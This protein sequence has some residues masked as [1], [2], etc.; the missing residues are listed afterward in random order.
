VQQYPD[1]DAQLKE[2]LKLLC[3]IKDV[4]R[5]I[6]ASVGKISEWAPILN[7]A[8]V[9]GASYCKGLH[10]KLLFSA[11]YGTYTVTL[12]DLQDLLKVSTLADQTNSPKAI[13][14]Q[15]KQENGFQE[16]WRRKRRAPDETDGT[17]KRAAVQE[18]RRSP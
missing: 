2:L 17:S 4:W 3:D 18:K 1:A 9:N 13:G 12:E 5:Y 6:P 16:V 8:E 11:L 15:T 10:G 14:Q 7:A